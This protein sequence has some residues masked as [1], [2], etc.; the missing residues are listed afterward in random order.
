M[1]LRLNLLQQQLSP[2]FMF[3]SLSVLQGLITIDSEK[4]EKYVDTLS[5]LDE[6][7]H[8]KCR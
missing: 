7:Y 1:K 6:I 5:D 2:H 4:A 3:N 8:P